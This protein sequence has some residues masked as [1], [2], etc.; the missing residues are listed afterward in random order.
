MAFEHFEPIEHSPLQKR[1]I[2]SLKKLAEN[3]KDLR[4]QHQRLSR[5]ITALNGVSIPYNDYQ[6]V[7]NF[8]FMLTDEMPEVMQHPHNK[9]FRE[10]SADCLK[11]LEESI[12]I[13]LQKSN[14][15]ARG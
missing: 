2:R 14:N 12:R 1:L 9:M 13:E 6:N 5:I 8:T 4:D 15:R 10:L 3:S 11:Q 7:F